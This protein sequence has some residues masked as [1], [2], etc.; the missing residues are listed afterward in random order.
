MNMK[1]TML[2][3]MVSLTLSLL[4]LAAVPTA[5]AQA[6]PRKINLFEYFEGSD[7]DLTPYKGKALFLNFFTEWCPYC[8]D[9]MP[10]IK[11][12]YETYSP[13]ALQVILVHVWDGEDQ[14]NSDSII[15]T[16]GLEDMTFFED[17]DMK[18][19]TL[20]SLTS[21]PLSV[22]F[23]KDGNIAV[24][25][26]GALTYEKMAATLDKLEVPLKGAGE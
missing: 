12:L 11:K 20:L 24:G 17:K 14:S 10:S 7:L 4:L 22:F 19:S 9:E 18:L 25:G 13:D 5:M 23:G 16:Y 6:E 2:R 3:R 26:S 1:Q 15:K 21:Y 8:M